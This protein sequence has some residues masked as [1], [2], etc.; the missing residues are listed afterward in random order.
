MGG[1]HRFAEEITRGRPTT[2]DASAR[3]RRMPQADDITLFGERTDR[4]LE[5]AM[6][7]Q[8]WKSERVAVVGLD[9]GDL[10]AYKFTDALR[11]MLL[12][13]RAGIQGAEN[14]LNDLLTR[15]G[16]WQTLALEIAI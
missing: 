13:Q 2:A 14:M 7:Q 6:A 3:I 12:H 15:R 10:F 9:L 16:G 4:L 8:H 5:D 1:N 11:E